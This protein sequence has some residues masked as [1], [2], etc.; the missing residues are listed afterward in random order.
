MRFIK[1]LTWSVSLLLMASVGLRAQPANEVKKYPK[2][3]YFDFRGKPLPDELTLTPLGS[4]PFVKSE[5]EGLRIT[6]PKDRK[7]LEQIVV[8]TRTGIQG[9]FE[10]TATMEILNAERAKDTFG[11]GVSLYINKV[12]PTAEGAT[13][14][15]ITKPTGEQEVFWDQSFGKTA[16]ERQYDLGHRP[17]TENQIRLRMKRTGTQL[18]YFVGKGFN[19]DHFDELPA[20]EFGGIDIK[21]V[22]VRVTTGGQRANLDVRLIDLRIRSGAAPET[23]IPETKTA[24]ESSN[25]WLLAALC[26]MVLILSLVVIV[27]AALL[28]RRQ[29]AVSGES[30][31]SN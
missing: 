11:V 9:D 24:G 13:L 30:K 4:D 27:L 8:G 19:G 29:G 5:P 21:Q 31:Q 22:I 2:E 12:N 6:L 20:K 18:A 10:I 23:P 7:N 14:G 28:F 15:R 3:V 26:V 1:C 16:E 17:Y 25:T